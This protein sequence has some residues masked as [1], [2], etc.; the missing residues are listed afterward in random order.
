MTVNKKFEKISC[1]SCTNS[2]CFVRQFCTP[3][4]I[5]KIDQKKYQTFYE[6][7]QFIIHEGAP[8]LGIYFIQNGKVKVLSRGLTGK[9]QIVRFA[10]EGH[11]LG[12]R[13][14]GNDVYPI[15]AVAMESSLICFV[16]NHILSELFQQNPEFTTGLMMYYSRELRKMEDRMKNI[17]QMNIRE[18]IA[19]SLLLMY[20]VFGTNEQ[21]EI[22]IH[23]TREDIANLAGTTAEQVVRQFTDFEE[24]G[25]IKKNARKIQLVNMDRL[26]RIIRDHNPHHIEFERNG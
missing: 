9:H 4:W 15:S 13:G 5:E 10:R 19:E 20:E 14:E 17:A 12:H 25:L 6:Q 24:E 1:K 16:D 7:G 23:F 26:Q 22:D 8:V 2:N 11:I 3:E 18:K 21:N